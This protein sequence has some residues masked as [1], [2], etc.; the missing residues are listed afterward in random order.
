MDLLGYKRVNVKSD[1]ENALKAVVSAAKVLWKGE[2]SIEHAPKGEKQ[3][4]GEVERAVRTVKAQV[5]TMKDHLE[6]Q[7]GRKVPNDDPSLPWL[8]KHA[9]ET[10]NRYL[11]ENDG[12]TAYQRVKGKGFKR[13]VA[14]FG[15]IVMYMIPKS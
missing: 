5:R 11:V 14:Y 2:M 3:S 8:I 15:E 4:N 13:D 12:K 6:A 1:Q 10:I 7:Y 9:P